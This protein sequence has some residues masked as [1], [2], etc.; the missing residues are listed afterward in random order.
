MV[1]NQVPVQA[2]GGVI[3]AGRGGGNAS[4]VGAKITG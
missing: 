3:D 1:C 4:L 2:Y